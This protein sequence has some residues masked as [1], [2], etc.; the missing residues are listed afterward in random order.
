MLNAHQ[1]YKIKQSHPCFAGHFPNNPIV[2][3]V[4][5]LDYLQNH[6]QLS[7]PNQRIKTLVTVKFTQP[8]RPE[9]IFTFDITLLEPHK[10]KFIGL[11][12][13]QKIIQGFFIATTPS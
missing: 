12:N 10:F 5:I 1:Y 2:P 11:S 7:Y 9:E 13:G 8:L 3:A 6:F 4:V